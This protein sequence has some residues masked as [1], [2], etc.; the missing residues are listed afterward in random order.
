MDTDGTWAAEFSTAS[1]TGTGVVVLDRDRIRGG[2][3]SYYYSGTLF[4]SGNKLTGWL[5]LTHYA[6]PLRSVFGPVRQLRL[7][8]DGAV[9]S[10]LIVAQGRVDTN[11]FARTSIKLRR[12]E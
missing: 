10:D 5:T 8:L 9:S 7:K 11:A 2:D 6:G 3:S 12:L 1:D 4:R